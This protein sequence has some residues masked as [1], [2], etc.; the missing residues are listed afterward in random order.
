[1][2]AKTKID[3]IGS[4]VKPFFLP[5]ILLFVLYS[6]SVS[7]KQAFYCLWAFCYHL[8]LVS[9]FTVFSLHIKQSGRPKEQKT[10]PPK[11]QHSK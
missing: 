9:F 11:K 4:K 3:V 2:G 5:L 10:V 6:V 7:Q 8:T 1:M